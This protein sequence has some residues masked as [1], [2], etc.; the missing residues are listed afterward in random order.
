MKR[1]LIFAFDAYYPNGGCGDVRGASD[2]LEEAKEIA[3]R[4]SFCGC[5]YAH[6]LDL[7]TM[8]VVAAGTKDG[9]KDTGYTSKPPVVSW[10]EGPTVSELNDLLEDC[11]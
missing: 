7:T 6:I 3:L 10:D 1:Y 5:G 9:T 8:Q 4:G 2:D 11:A